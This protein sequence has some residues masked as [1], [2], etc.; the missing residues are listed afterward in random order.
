MEGDPDDASNNEHSSFPADQVGNE[1]SI[2]HHEELNITIQNTTSEHDKVAAAEAFIPLPDDNDVLFYAMEQPLFHQ[3]QDQHPGNIFYSKVLE[4]NEHIY[5]TAHTI[6]EKNQIVED[7]LKRIK[8]SGARFLDKKDALL[9]EIPPDE[10]REKISQA[11]RG[12]AERIIPNVPPPPVVDSTDCQRFVSHDSNVTDRSMMC[13]SSQSTCYSSMFVS[14][15]EE[16]QSIELNRAISLDL[17]RDLILNI[18]DRTVTLDRS[19]GDGNKKVSIDLRMESLEEVQLDGSNAGEKISFQESTF[20]YAK[21]SDFKAFTYIRYIGNDSKTNAIRST[22][23]D[24]PLMINTANGGKITMVPNLGNKCN[25]RFNAIAVTDEGCAGTEYEY[26]DVAQGDFVFN[27]E[28]SEWTWSKKR[29]FSGM[30]ENADDSF[31]DFIIQIDARAHEIKEVE[32]VDFGFELGG[33]A[34]ML[35]TNRYYVFDQKSQTDLEAFMP[36]GYPKMTKID[37][38][39]KVN[40]TFRFHR[41]GT[42]IFYDPIISFQRLWDTRRG[43]FDV[44]GTIRTASYPVRFGKGTNVPVASN[45]VNAIEHARKKVFHYPEEDLDDLMYV[46]QCDR[47]GYMK[48]YVRVD[49]KDRMRVKDVLDDLNHPWENGDALKVSFDATFIDKKIENSEMSVL[50]NPFVGSPAETENESAGD[51]SCCGYSTIIAATLCQIF[52][53]SRFLGDLAEAQARALYREMLK[54][55]VEV[56]MVD[57]CAGDK[58]GEQVM[59]SLHHMTTLVAFCSSNYGAKTGNVYSTYHE[60]KYANE[61]KK[62]ILPIKICNE[63]PPAPSDYEGRSQNDF[64]FGKDMLYLDWSGREWDAAECAKEVKAAFD[65]KHNLA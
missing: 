47:I 56:F 64:V 51:E 6:N 54:L 1:T 41:F 58:F 32:D 5:N 17:V 31:L 42:K 3:H 37:D 57:A 50:S 25:L 60:L 53:S 44:Q 2:D 33:H 40:L 9:V 26:W 12:R 29:S 34:R 45:F 59:T 19:I 38:E 52:I 30:N 13:F 36:E 35:L 20:S 49:V 46:V 14:S 16:S 65:R 61:H 15:Q 21:E 63:W 43:T 48:K 28:I 8:S 39:D 4:E 22:N 27:F 7:I 11:L 55:G 18:K 10:A 62:H 23:Y 24:N